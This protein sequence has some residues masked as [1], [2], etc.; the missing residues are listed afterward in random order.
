MSRNILEVS[1]ENF[2]K[3]VDSVRKKVGNSVEIMPIVKANGY[4]S[5]INRDIDVMNRFKIVG[6]A[7]V[8]EAIDLR[9]R[10][11]NGDIFVLNQPF[12]D[13]IDDIC[14]YNLVV[15][16]SSIEFLEEV[17]KTNKNIRIHIEVET[18]MG[19]TGV[20][21]KD[22]SIFL[23]YVSSNNN[24][25]VEGI[26]THLSS[27]DIDHDFTMKQIDL[28]NNKVFAVKEV[29]PNIKYIHMAASNAIL[30]YDLGL[31]NMIRPG[32]ILY[33]YPSSKS[34]LGKID[35][36]PVLKLKS[37]IS[38]IKDVY[39]GDSIGY[40]RSFV[41][42]R[43]L[44]V[45]TIGI[46]YADGVRRALGNKG[47]VSIKGKKC[48]IIGNVCMDSIMV[49]VSLIDDVRISDDVYLFDN[50]IVDVLEI[51]NI[52]NTIN[53]EIISSIGERVDRVFVD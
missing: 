52:C 3:N 5:Y 30:N 27:S 36:F 9:K 16:V 41:A 17:V 37:K 19:R 26:Y 24:I 42:D 48:R 43:Q 47:Y 44:K 35:L 45:A 15:G 14:S 10:G 32:I 31:C 7:R 34:C 18:G 12:I 25:L 21:D 46:G 53:Y 1:R 49:D 4:G 38:F 28:F 23:D 50:N 11:Y 6:V 22:F 8:L 2:F 39:P 29:F 40:G 20:S 13:E 51:A 33:G